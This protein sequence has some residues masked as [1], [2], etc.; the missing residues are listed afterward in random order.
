[1]CAPVCKNEHLFCVQE[2]Q[3]GVIRWSVHNLS[4]EE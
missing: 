3:E 4:F 1:M 2:L